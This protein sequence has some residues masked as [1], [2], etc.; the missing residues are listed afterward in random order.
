MTSR[1]TS[2]ALVAVTTVSYDVPQLE[3]PRRTHLPRSARAGDCLR[4]RSGTLRPT[5]ETRLDRTA[6]HPGNQLR[7]RLVGPLRC[8]HATRAHV[9][10][11]G[12]FRSR[13][14]IGAV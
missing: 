3:C 1:T 9:R 7:E 4:Y 2:C 12:A 8:T 5:A 13:A 11:G 10:A 14:G 6:L